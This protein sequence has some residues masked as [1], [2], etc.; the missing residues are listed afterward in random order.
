MRKIIFFFAAA[1]LLTAPVEMGCC[2]QDKKVNLQ[3]PIPEKF[4]LDDLEHRTFL[5]F[6]ELADKVSGQIPDRYPTEAF[7]SIAA[8]GFGLSAYLV[9]VE[10]Q[11][12]T[13]QEAA[14]RVAKTLRFLYGLPQGPEKSGI[15]GYKGL[16][17][18]FN[19]IRT[20]MR[21]KDVELSTIDTGL[22]MAGILSCMSYFNGD[23]AVE[24]EI[25]DLADKL[26]RRVE[27]DWALNGNDIL[28]MGWHP[29]SGFLHS[30][31]YGYNEAMILIIMAIGSPTH[32]IPA[33]SW[34]AWTSK[35]NWA[36][37][38]GYEHVN[39]G[40]LF[41][42]QFSHMYIDFR[43]IFDDY[44][45]AKGI[46]YFENSR[47]ATY[48]QQVYCTENPRQFNDYSRDIWGLTACDG[49]GYAT[50]E[51]KGK[52]MVFDGYSARGTAADY[53]VDDGTIAPTAAGGSIPFAP[54]ICIS[55]LEAMFNKYG[56][57]LYQ[58]YGFK[59]AFNPSFTWGKGNEKGWF[60][61][62]YIGLDQGPIVL[63]IE[64]Y[65]TGLLWNIMKRNPY[66][67]DGLKKAGFAGGWLER[68]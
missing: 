24:M 67:V 65:R 48:A 68:Q 6:W 42:H 33:S 11:Y 43:G 17:Y 30:Y 61:I 53:N 60:D 1:M 12:I 15:G 22:L 32:P 37:W 52:K 35:Y 45:R 54:E 9:G 25:R 16:F 23:D 34:T 58:D 21:F 5:Y 26:F 62:D 27:W 66:I 46:D 57:A 55:A 18:H 39:F 29:E 10:R 4:S 20:G 28:C 36:S 40:P 50:H 13:R 3:R 63:M 47:R 56:D 14:E 8:T 19:D 2:H 59:D 51:W 64:N 44:M 41:G 49:P 38:K 31:W 7:S